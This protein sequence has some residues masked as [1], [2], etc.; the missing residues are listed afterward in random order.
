MRKVYSIGDQEG[1]N[2]LLDPKNEIWAPKEYLKNKIY[3]LKAYFRI[4]DP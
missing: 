2:K 4:L 3:I 1:V